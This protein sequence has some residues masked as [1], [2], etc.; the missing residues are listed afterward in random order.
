MGIGIIGKAISGAGAGA[1]LATQ[2][3]M[4]A[5]I[6]KERDERLNSYAVS[7]QQTQQKF[8]TGERVGTEKFQAGESEKNRALQS[9][10]INAVV[11]QAQVAV[12]EGKLKIDSLKRAQDLQNA[13]VNETDPEKKDQLADQIY[14]LAGKDKFLPIMTRDEMGNPVFSGGFNT[15]TGQRNTPI[16]NAAPPGDVNSI[17]DSVLGPKKP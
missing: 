7:S 12:Q 16:S 13:Y 10:Q 9:R 15:R 6:M 5:E 11:A 14:T 17:L 1:G 3:A 8:Q 2:E 4:R